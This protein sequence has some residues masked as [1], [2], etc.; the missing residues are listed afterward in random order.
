MNLEAIQKTYR[1]YAGVYDALFG[2]LFEPGRRRAVESI[3]TRPGQ[4][5]LE[6]G[7]GTGL[8]LPVYRRDARVTGIDVSPDMLAKARERVAQQGLAHVEALLEMDAEAMSFPNHS[9]DSVVA[10]YVASVVPDPKR[11]LAEMKRVCVPGG[12]VVVV[13]HFASDH[14][15]LRHVERAVA[16]LSSTMG[17]RPDLEL[18]SLQRMAGMDVVDVQEINAF[19]YWKMV[20]FRSTG[21]INGHTAAINAAAG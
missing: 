4:R 5:I 16:P 18:P 8:S 11:L 2:S 7:V 10:M 12:E 21:G 14:P 1:R 9:F 20:R 15:V 6:V 19:G 17:F 3:N 13:N